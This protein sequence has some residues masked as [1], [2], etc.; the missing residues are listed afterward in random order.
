MPVP[1]VRPNTLDAFLPPDISI[2]TDPV[3]LGKGYVLWRIPK[4]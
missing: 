1:L 3:T 2:G 4:N